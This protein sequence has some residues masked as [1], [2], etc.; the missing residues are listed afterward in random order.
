MNRPASPRCTGALRRELPFA[1][2]PA[3][4]C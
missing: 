2:P 4:L 1:P 3:C